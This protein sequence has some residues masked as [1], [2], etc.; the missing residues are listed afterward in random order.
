MT[1][2]SLPW[3]PAKL[4]FLSK[5]P[6]PSGFPIFKVAYAFDGTET[7]I[8]M[9]LFVFYFAVIEAKCYWCSSKTWPWSKSILWPFE[10]STKQASTQLRRMIQY[11]F[12][13]TL[14]KEGLNR[15]IP[16]HLACINMPASDRGNFCVIRTWSASVVI[17]IVN[18]NIVIILI[19][20]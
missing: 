5:W 6:R 20:Y 13:V 18:Y 10:P 9:C 4:W 8:K 14:N 11:L 12:Y 16:L 15:P 7:I 1:N 19:V 3:S 2:C 17:P